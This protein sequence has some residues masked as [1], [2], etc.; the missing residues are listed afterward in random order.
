LTLVQ[1]D[2]AAGRGMRRASSRQASTLKR[3]GA[4]RSHG[5][6]GGSTR[7]LLEH[8]GHS[9]AEEAEI[10]KCGGGGMILEP[11]TLE[12]YF[13]L[14]FIVFVDLLCMYS[15]HPCTA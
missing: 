15:V 4:T 10:H 13:M 9:V 5:G 8:P 1:E 14:I 2:G 3:S 6:R 11:A 12:D 7:L